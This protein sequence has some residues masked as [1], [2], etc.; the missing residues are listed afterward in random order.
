[1]R[2]KAP[3]TAPVFLSLT[4]G[5][6]AVVGTDY[7]ELEP[8]FHREAIAAGCL[9]FGVEAPAPVVAEPSFDRR[10]VILDAINEMLDGAV[11]GDFTGDGKPDVRKLSAKVG[12][13]V[14]RNERDKLFA[15][16]TK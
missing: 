6:T 1:M 9:P 11:E 12:F 13:T 10:K 2:F 3:G 7:T 15:E 8:M 16:A 5:N 14:D 4:S